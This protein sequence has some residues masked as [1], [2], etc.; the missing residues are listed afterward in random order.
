MLKAVF[1]TLLLK[2]TLHPFLSTQTYCPTGPGKGCMQISRAL[3]KEGITYMSSLINT[4]SIRKLVWLLLQVSRNLSLSWTMFLLLM[5][6]QKQSL[7]IMAFHT[8]VMKWRSMR[9]EKDLGCHLLLQ[10][11]LNV[12]ALWKVL[13]R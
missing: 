4:P 6:I 10:M 11:I 8:P 2:L 5:D 12:M 7:Q 9:R 3:S 1:Y 13:S